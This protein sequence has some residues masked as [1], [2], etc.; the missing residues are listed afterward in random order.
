[1]S[2][3][4]FFI[5][6][7]MNIIFAQ[8]RPIFLNNKWS[9]SKYL[10]VLN[11]TLPLGYNFHNSKQYKYSFLA[12][13]KKSVCCKIVYIFFSCNF[14]F[15]QVCFTVYNWSML[16]LICCSGW[17]LKIFWNIYY[18]IFK[19]RYY[20]VHTHRARGCIVYWITTGQDF[21]W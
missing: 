17:G 13:N 19:G 16:S 9:F 7:L 11:I 2:V 4:I 12:N 8:I 10:F 6:T 18:I 15:V 1:M 3:Y 21:L 5:F 14:C 20:I